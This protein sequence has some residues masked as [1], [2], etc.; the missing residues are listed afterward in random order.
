MSFNFVDPKG[1]PNSSLCLHKLFKY[2]SSN[3]SFSSTLSDYPVLTSTNLTYG[4]IGFYSS[5]VLADPHYFLSSLTRNTFILDH[6]ISPSQSKGSIFRL[7][8]ADDRLTSVIFNQ[9]LL[10]A[11][12]QDRIYQYLLSLS[13]QST[14]SFNISYPKSADLTV[15]TPFSL[16]VKRSNILSALSKSS[17]S[18]SL[19]SAWLRKIRSLNGNLIVSTKSQELFVSPSFNIFPK[20]LF[21]SP[22][23]IPFSS[24]QEVCCPTS[25]MLVP[26][27]LHSI[28]VYLSSDHPLYPLLGS[29][30]PSLSTSD[31]VDL[32]MS[33]VTKTSFSL[34]MLPKLES[35][36]RELSY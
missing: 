3:C 11:S 9:C 25:M 28:P 27:I 16:L 24:F 35:Y 20:R 8:Y 7:A 1:T 36:L 4:Y 12:D 15:A 32:V 26:F 10:D 34:S 2:A 22:V 14:F 29:Y 13:K 21:V 5:R 18:S 33:C 30:V 6:A 17:S 19:T 23:K 31:A